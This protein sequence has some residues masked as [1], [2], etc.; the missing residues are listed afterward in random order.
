M[1]LA[2]LGNLIWDICLNMRTFNTQVIL[3]L[4]FKKASY[5]EELQEDFLLLLLLKLDYFS[6]PQK[7]R[8]EE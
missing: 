6:T 3:N 5:F 8:H 7:K 4:L 1:N 2:R